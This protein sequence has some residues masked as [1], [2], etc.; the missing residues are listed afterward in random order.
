MGQSI[1]GI[2]RYIFSILILISYSQTILHTNNTSYPAQE[3]KELVFC[4]IK[5]KY[6]LYYLELTFIYS[7]RQTQRSYF[8]R[9][10]LERFCLIY[11]L[12]RAWIED[13]RLRAFKYAFADKIKDNVFF[14]LP[15]VGFIEL[16]LIHIDR[17]FTCFCFNCNTQDKRCMV[18]D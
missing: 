14:F 11:I 2:E 6:F 9:I 7:S 8:L 4:H 13:S 5:N 1:S 12:T 10:L 15:V 16:N 18:L 3:R 17:Y